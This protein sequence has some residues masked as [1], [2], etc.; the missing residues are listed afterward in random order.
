M[1]CFHAMRSSC[2]S[3]FQFSRDAS[4]RS[5][6]RPSDFARIPCSMRRQL[7]QR[8]FR[9]LREVFERRQPLPPR[10]RLD[11][12][13]LQW[14]DRDSSTFLAELC[15]PPQQP[16]LLLLLSHPTKTGRPNATLSYLHHVIANRRFPGNWHHPSLTLLYV[17]DSRQAPERAVAAAAGHG[18]HARP[19]HRGSLRR[20]AAV[21]R[22]SS[23][24]SPAR[25]C[26][27]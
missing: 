27:S 6:P 3:C 16:G 8:T 4:R 19:H 23:R 2:P 5:P 15:A 7:R 17:E 21:V 25:A 1:R 9:A 24:A 14:G 22:N 13:H 20:P 11:R 10:C 26:R 12:P 18:G